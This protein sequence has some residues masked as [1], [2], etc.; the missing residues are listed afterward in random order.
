MHITSKWSVGGIRTERVRIDVE[1]RKLVGDAIDRAEAVDFAG[2][3][4]TRKLLVHYWAVTTGWAAAKS[5]SG[6]RKLA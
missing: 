3:I 1:V 5:A 2:A 4:E 6:R